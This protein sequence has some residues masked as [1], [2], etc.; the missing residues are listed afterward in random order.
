MFSSP[1]ISKYRFF[2]IIKDR[3]GNVNKKRNKN[4]LKYKKNFRNRIIDSRLIYSKVQKK[5][6]GKV[7]GCEELFKRFEIP[8]Q[9]SEQAVF[10]G[11]VGPA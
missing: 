6:Q 11:Q 9:Y 3:K 7:K 2:S 1:K 5:M 10:D 4:K 8:F